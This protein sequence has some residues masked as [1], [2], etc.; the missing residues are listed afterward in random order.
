MGQRTGGRHAGVRRLFIPLLAALSVVVL[1]PARAGAAVPG[2]YTLL[3]SGGAP[4]EL[5]TTGNL[6][7]GPTDDAVFYLSTTGTGHA[8]LPFPLR[9]YDQSYSEIAISTNGN[10]Q[11]GVLP[12][13][14]TA[15]FANDCL[16]SAT[17]TRPAIAVLWDDLLFNSDDPE[18]GF[19]QGVFTSTTGTAPYRRF[20]V[21]WQ[22]LAVI[23]GQ[24]VLAQ[25]VFDEGSPAVMFVYG[26]PGGDSATVGVQDPQRRAATQWTCAS[27]IDSSVSDGLRLRFEYTP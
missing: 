5:Q 11:L 18:F 12:G 27:G 20:V 8:R 16:P 9:V 6:I 17:L 1:D 13:I 15:G 26:A 14:G 4:F 22:G 23:T 10:I 21:S 2:R 3:T 24:P 7:S 19:Q 25:A